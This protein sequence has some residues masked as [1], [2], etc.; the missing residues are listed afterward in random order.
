MQ[1]RKNMMQFT[2]YVRPLFIGKQTTA[3]QY[4]KLCE[5]REMGFC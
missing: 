3:V 1:A 2:I 4:T 5:R